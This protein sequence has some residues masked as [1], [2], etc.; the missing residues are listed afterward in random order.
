M[1]SWSMNFF[2]PSELIV[3][4]TIDFVTRFRLKPKELPMK[5]AIE[6]YI[7]PHPSVLT[8]SIQLYFCLHIHGWL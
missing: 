4:T 2:A 7:S 1:G 6:E 8:K 3:I 5:I